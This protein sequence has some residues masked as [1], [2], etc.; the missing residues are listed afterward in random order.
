MIK[1]LLDGYLI[2]LGFLPVLII[3]FFWFFFTTGLI[4]RLKGE[5]NEEVKL[6][7]TLQKASI[8]ILIILVLQ[9]GLAGYLWLA[10]D[11]NMI[12]MV[13]L[14]FVY[15]YI[16]M[17]SVKFTLTHLDRI[18]LALLKKGKSK[19]GKYY[20]TQET[21]T[22]YNKDYYLNV[23]VLFIGLGLLFL[24][25]FVWEVGLLLSMLALLVF[26]IA[27]GYFGAIQIPNYIK[28]EYIDK[29]L[30]N[31][32]EDE[33]NTKVNKDKDKDKEV[34]EVNSEKSEAMKEESGGK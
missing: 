3:T 4:R 22:V 20:L 32:E 12:P 34:S 31:L 23:V 11:V 26:Y 1:G 10:K 33:T 7:D 9:I 2:T 13:L 19:R 18:E 6:E 21:K 29:V 27:V 5:S 16:S 24:L 25:G 8:P 30:S 17:L 15:F 14:N 28:F